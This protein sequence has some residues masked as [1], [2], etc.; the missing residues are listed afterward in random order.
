MFENYDEVLTVDQ[1]REILFIGKNT[2]Y[3]LLNSG[4]IK[5]FK[6]GRTH[7]VPRQAL[8]DYISRSCN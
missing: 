5:S 2:V 3:K 6:I 7:K 8:E 1:V 4:K